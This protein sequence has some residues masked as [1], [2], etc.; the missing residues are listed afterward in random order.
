[1]RRFLHHF[2]SLG[3]ILI[4]LL[5]SGEAPHAL[6]LENS[7]FARL[8]AH[9]F[10]KQ[11][12]VG[13][14]IAVVD[15]GS[16]TIKF[17]AKNGF[18][19]EIVKDRYFVSLGESL[20]RTGA[21]DEAAYKS[22]VH[23]LGETKKQLAKFG[24]DIDDATV[25]A[26]AGIRDAKNRGAILKKLS[27]AGFHPRVLSEMEEAE[28]VYRAVIGNRSL[29][30][31]GG[32]AIEVG[33]GSTEIVYGKN[34]TQIDR[35]KTSVIKAGTG[36]LG[37]KDPFSFTE[38]RNAAEKTR[39]L[40]ESKSPRVKLSEHNPEAFIAQKAKFKEFRR[41]HEKET[42]QD[43]FKIGITDELMD[44]Y[45]SPPGLE[46][47]KK[48]TDKAFNKGDMEAAQSLRT[49]SANFAIYREI[50]RH[51]GLTKISFGGKGGLKEALLKEKE[52]TLVGQTI[53]SAT[54][55]L[56][57]LWNAEKTHV[58]S[59]L[60]EIFPLEKF[61]KLE[62]RVKS[63]AS[64]ES[65]IV[66]KWLRDRTDVKALSQI[67]KAKQLVDDG[68]GARL[69]LKPSTGNDLNRLYHAL[70]SEIESG[71]VRVDKISNYQVS[72]AAPYLSESQVVSIAES[73]RKMT[74][75]A[76]EVISGRNAEKISGYTGLHLDLVYP[77]GTQVELQIR[78]VRV[79][80]LAEIEH[81]VYDIRQGKA[82]E[83]LDP[84]MVRTVEK[85]STNQYSDLMSYIR[86]CYLYARKTE[87]GYAELVPAL[88]P[89]LRKYPELKFTRTLTHL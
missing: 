54:E 10:E 72:G 7:C 12:L 88:P 31:Q 62:F 35:E 22:L 89:S 21:L 64:T 5:I 59:H 47:L 45:L 13:R 53:D 83:K 65:K 9:Q 63:I 8:L 55:K 51:H 66:S 25:V 67:E 29:P 42:G 78:G 87:A 58:I 75:K 33:G 69:T 71:T 19:G 52:A 11:P 4:L 82:L 32:V 17:Y 48:A 27:Q 68:I 6:A 43:I 15:I 61:G 85:L 56:N 28:I 80:H 73:V 81:K 39:R 57:V 30:Q 34:L 49:I 20:G 38:I 1:M 16:N 50:K 60:E 76:P 79:S 23:G 37:M 41:L 77:N 44:F 14:N 46:K 84:A 2:S 18:T 3:R 40:L 74:G 70:L 26:T 36:S 86:E 24:I